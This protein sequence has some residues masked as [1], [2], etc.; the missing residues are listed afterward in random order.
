MS[1]P[2]TV[3]VQE[4]ITPMVWVTVHDV[5]WMP[6]LVVQLPGP[7]KPLKPQLVLVQPI[8]LQAAALDTLHEKEAKTFIMVIFNRIRCRNWCL[9][10]HYIHFW[11]GRWW[12][13]LQSPRRLSD[14]CIGMVSRCCRWCRSY[15]LNC[16]CSCRRLIR[17]YIYSIAATATR[18]ISSNI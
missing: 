10:K 3:R 7:S 1:V 16:P 12:W 4:R 5:N 11:R 13:Y 18:L 6:L 8:L 15:C 14:C 2:G 9:I 17:I